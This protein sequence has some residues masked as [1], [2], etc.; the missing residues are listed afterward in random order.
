M[1]VL[2]FDTAMGVCSA[3]V[4]HDGVI[5][6]YRLTNQARGHAE[7]VMDMVADVLAEA[8]ARVADMDRLGVTIGPGTFTGQRIGLAAARA[9]VLGTTTQ[10]VGVST[11]EAVA[12][13]VEEAGPEDR[14]AVVF[15]ARRGEVYVQLFDVR[16]TGV[17]EPQ[18]L[19]PERAAAL[20]RQK[21]GRGRLILAGTGA[22]LVAPL[23]GG[24]AAEVVLS[25]AATQPDS[26]HVARLAECA[27]V[28]QSGAPSPLYL[29][30][31]DAKLPG[32]ASL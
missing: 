14:I 16:L 17:S 6:A 5:Q 22:G 7:T 32:A 13:G 23:L 9:M 3:A 10:L 28:T 4:S 26:R 24:I 27:E 12:A 8:G 15:D 25:E 31:P 1:K 20:L 18:V 29:R 11:L 2:A 21:A 19:T 30:A